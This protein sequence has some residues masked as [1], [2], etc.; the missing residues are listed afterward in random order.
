MIIPKNRNR[1]YD[2]LEYDYV[3]AIW[4]HLDNQ[5]GNGG[6]S[7]RK[8]SKML[9]IIKK[10]PY[11]NMNNVKNIK[12]YKKDVE[13]EDVYFS[14]LCESVKLNKPSISDAKKFASETVI[15]SESFGIHKCWNGT[16]IEDILKIFPEAE[17]LYKLQGLEE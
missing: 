3:G 17:E 7:L 10:C 14:L 9:E 4:P 12:K 13:N 5:I 2:Y 11:T 16:S 8:K 15:D 6:F 1:I